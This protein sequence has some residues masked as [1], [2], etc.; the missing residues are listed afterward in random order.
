MS[1]DVSKRLGF[2]PLVRLI[3]L[4]LSTVFLR[5]PIMGLLLILITVGELSE[6]AFEWCDLHFPGFR[7]T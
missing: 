7:R 1:A 4:A 5:V 3:G 2:K 6:D